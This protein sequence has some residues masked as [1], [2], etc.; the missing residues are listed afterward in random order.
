[1]SGIA[2]IL[3]FDGSFTDPALLHR[4]TDAMAHR[5]PD[6]LA[7]W[8]GPAA[9]LGQ[10]RLNTTP[11]SLSETLPLLSVDH[12]RVL[13]MDG[14]IDNR[15]ELVAKLRDR[16]V[17]LRDNSDAEL[18]LAACGE[19]DAEAP[20]HIEGDF[21]FAL[22]DTRKRRLLAARD[23]AG[24]RP[25]FYHWDGKRFA[26]ASEMKALLTL[27]WVPEKLFDPVVAEFIAFEW[28]EPRKT[29]W[30]GIDRLQQAHVLTSDGREPRQSEYWRPDTTAEIRYKRDSDYTDHYLHLLETVVQQHTRSHKPVAFE[31]SGGLDSS[32]L[33]C[34][35]DRMQG[36]GRLP[37]PG[38]EGYS[39]M[40]NDGSVA[41]EQRYVQAVE[42]FLGRS[43]QRTDPTL[44]PLETLEDFARRE[45]VFA[46][47]PTANMHNGIN[48]VA[49]GA[50]QVVKITGIG[51]DDWLG[52]S[53]IFYADALRGL[54]LNRLPDLLRADLDDLGL[55][56]TLVE[57]RR[58]GLEPLL[59][60]PLVAAL[61]AAYSRAIGRWDKADLLD[62]PLGHGLRRNRRQ[63]PPGG[64]FS[65]L[66]LAHRERMAQ[67]FHPFMV[68]L[69]ETLNHQMSHAGLEHRAPLY[70]RPMIE[71]SFTIGEM[72]K[73]H[74]GTN[75]A[76]H[77]QSMHGI[78]PEDVRTRRDKAWFGD[79]IV[80]YFPA[81]EKTL[82]ASDS[83]RTCP[84]LARS[85]TKDDLLRR[86]CSRKHGTSLD[87]ALWVANSFS[88]LGSGLR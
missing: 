27:P 38:L 56:R 71:F 34:V 63:P 47:Y 25:F 50:G 62:A 55:Y 18:A 45:R 65:G 35:A 54:A 87:W 80:P 1:M 74:G 6:G 83:V 64:P 32:A 75:R 73:R 3:H 44:P 13:V 9:A 57:F 26:F 85:D 33:F 67:L 52:G 49:R 79:L 39:L 12:S 11:E 70:A 40:F 77:V 5:G 60:A 78:L 37:A 29:Y 51:G 84:W 58:H 23:H 76:L 53:R 66:C 10:L 43:I 68:N 72:R 20:R 22:W 86:V 28:H 88:E 15:T 69:F 21:A 17:R 36:Q 7:H 82:S 24:M 46:P 30:Q 81:L 31:V 8:T 61:R 48:A 16:G 19:W 41:D 2:G 59:P 4:M 14:R 42:R